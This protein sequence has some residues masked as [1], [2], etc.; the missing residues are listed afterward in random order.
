MLQAPEKS[1][2]S[3]LAVMDI[4]VHLVQLGLLWAHVFKRTDELPKLS[5]HRLVGQSLVGRLGNTE[6]DDLGDGLM[7]VF[8]DEDIRWF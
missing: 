2:I 4:D 8:G 7:I 6:I 3:D 1:Q 5:E